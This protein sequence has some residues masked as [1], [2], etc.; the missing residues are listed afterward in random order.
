MMNAERFRLA[1]FTTPEE[2]ESLE[3]AVAVLAGAVVGL[4]LVIVAAVAVFGL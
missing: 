2:T 1:K 4:V 3:G